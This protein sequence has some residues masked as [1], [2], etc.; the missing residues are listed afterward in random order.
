[1]VIAVAKRL[2]T[3]AP[4]ILIGLLGGLPFI[5]GMGLLCCEVSEGLCR[6]PFP[7]HGRRRWVWEGFPCSG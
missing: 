1:M 7:C 2:G 4:T 3:L 5:I 6:A